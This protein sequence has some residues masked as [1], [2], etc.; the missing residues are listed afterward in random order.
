MK[1]FRIWAKL[2]CFFCCIFLQTNWKITG[3]YFSLFFTTF[4]ERPET[5]N[6]FNLGHFWPF[7]MVI[8]YKK[9]LWYKGNFFM[10]IPL[11]PGVG[12]GQEIYCRPLAR[13][14]KLWN[15]PHSVWSLII[16]SSK[17]ILFGFSCNSTILIWEMRVCNIL[18]RGRSYCVK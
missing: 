16:S 5:G 1:V 17:K 9:L 14:T 11:D 13:P 7:V 15:S 4:L 6:F 18:Q 8:I 10:Y 3:K 2:Y 12:Q